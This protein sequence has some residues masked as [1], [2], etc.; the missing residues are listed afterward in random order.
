VNAGEIVSAVISSLSVLLLTAITRAMIGFRNDLRRFMTEHMW[1]ISTTL[2][3]RDKVMHIM[4][5]MDLESDRPPPDDLP[6]R[7]R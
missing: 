4:S 6:P 7:I 1:L 5:V 3:T 2:W